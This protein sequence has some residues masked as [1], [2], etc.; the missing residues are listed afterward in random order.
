MKI[1]TRSL[2]FGVHQFLWHPVTVVIAWRKLYGRL[3]HWH[4]LIAI[5]LH[6][7]GYWGLPNIDGAEG[8]EHPVRGAAAASRL[9]LRIAQ[10]IWW[11]RNV[12]RRLL[13][14]APLSWSGRMFFSV[15]R[16][17]DSHWLA[18]FHSR[19]YSRS[20]GVWP[21][22]LCWADKMSILYDPAPFYLLRV[23]LSG[24]LKEFIA[25]SPLHNPTPIEWLNWYRGKVRNLV[26]ALP[27]GYIDEVR[28]GVDNPSLKMH[29]VRHEL[30]SW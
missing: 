6:D 28:G 21:S 29:R 3:P 20:K 24:E 11:L 15:N 1:G 7:I 14:R 22:A 2:L 25:N 19:E 12:R 9:V 8:R 30:V 4:E 26:A 5:A 23:W 17:L 16:A 27:P 10:S 13:G 18:L